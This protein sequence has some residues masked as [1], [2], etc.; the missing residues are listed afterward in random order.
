MLPQPKTTMLLE[1]LSALKLCPDPFTLFRFEKEAE[2]LL[3]SGFSDGWMLKGIIAALKGCKEDTV[4][5]FECAIKSEPIDQYHYNYALSLLYLSC[6][7]EA[8]EQAWAAYFLFQNEI[9]AANETLDCLLN[10]GDL[11]RALIVQNNLYK[12]DLKCKRKIHLYKNKLVDDG[13]DLNDVLL[14]F[15]FIEELF[16]SHSIYSV[17]HSDWS[18]EDNYLL[19]KF[20]LSGPNAKYSVLDEIELSFSELIEKNDLFDVLD[21][22]DIQFDLHEKANVSEPDI[23]DIPTSNTITYRNLTPDDLKRIDTALQ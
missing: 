7:K 6:F 2:K 5:Y 18:F 3:E 17:E 16:K 19:V 10:I 4:K 12:L 21:S 11:N 13:V 8:A 14:V 23:F 1:Q 22:I 9:D 15:S 20:D